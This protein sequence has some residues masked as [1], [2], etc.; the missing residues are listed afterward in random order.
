MKREVA[1]IIE[2]SSVYGRDLLSGVVRYMRIHDQWSVFLAQRDLW[3]RAPSWLHDWKG[4]GILSR[5][6][7]PELIDA[8]GR[9]GVP[10]VEMTDRVE[11]SV[12]P[13]VRSDD[14]AIG[15]VAA[16]HFIERG[17]RRF[18]FCGFHGE[19]WSARRENA[20]VDA[21]EQK[22]GVCCGIFNSAW[23]GPAERPWHEEQACIARWLRSIEPP[24]GVFAC[25]DLRGQHVINVAHRLNLAVPEQVAILGVDNDELI[26]RVCSPPMSSVIPNAE[27]VGFRAAETLARMME[28]Q[29][30]PSPIQRVGPLGIAIRQS[31]DMMAIDDRDVAAALR[32]IRQHACAGISVEDVVGKVS[33]SRST[34]ERQVRKF[35]GRTPQEEIRHNQIKRVKE[36]LTTTDM[37][38]EKIATLCGFDHPEYMHVVFKRIA[39]ET[40]GQFRRKIR[41]KT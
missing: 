30:P 22:Y 13:Q 33:L 32:F 18:G 10:M 9:T 1:L 34:L 2:T 38:A 27:F 36:L 31:T 24:F 17:F 4:D 15:Q 5:A 3:T 19:A 37:A 8:I 26:C 12:L 6:T 41:P 16:E 14:S 11:E 28:G 35:L 23:H 25:N 20:F 7:T 21:V 40:P 39:G 29:A